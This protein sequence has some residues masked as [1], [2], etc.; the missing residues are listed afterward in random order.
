M[1]ALPP[2]LTEDKKLVRARP[3][4]ELALV[5]EAIPYLLTVGL[6]DRAP[7]AAISQ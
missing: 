4:L 5:N 7:E 2:L 1:R 3:V 6:F